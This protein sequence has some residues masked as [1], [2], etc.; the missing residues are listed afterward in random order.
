MAEK[1]KPCYIFMLK[2]PGK[3]NLKIELFRTSLWPKKEWLGRNKWIRK[4]TGH[5]AHVRFRIRI[6]GR[7]NMVDGKDIA[8]T[9]YEFRDILWRT[10]KKAF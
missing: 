3:K 7:W 10:I 8:F 4:Y 6:N 1:R 5:E 9:K 2:K